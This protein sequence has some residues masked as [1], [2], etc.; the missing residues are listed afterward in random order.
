M[1]MIQIS[2]LTFAY[3]GSY[4]NVFTGLSLRLDTDWRTG[5]VA[6]NGRGKT[7]LLN[8]LR[9]KYPF[10]GTIAAS[11]A[12][13]YFPF[14]VAGGNSSTL[15]VLEEMA[16]EVESW[17]LFKELAALEVDEGAL[18]RPFSTLSNGERTKCLLAL[19]FLRENRFLLIDEPTN[20]LDLEGRGAVSR[21]LRRQK[22]FLL[23]S[24][25][26]AFLD[27]CVDHIVSLDKTGVTVQ[28]GD[29]SSW[30]ENRSRQEQWERAE[31]E[32]L[33]A[34]ISRLE[35]AARRTANWSDRIEATKI[36]Q[37]GC[38]RGYVG[39]QAARMMKRSKAIQNRRQSAIEEKR[40]LLKN[41]EYAQELKL[42]PLPHPKRRLAEI[43]D[44]APDYGT[45]PICKPFSFTVE[46]GER[47]ALVGRNGAGKSSLLK[48]IAGEDIPHAGTVA[49]A[50]GLVASIVPQDPSFLSGSPVEYAQ[51]VGADLTL[52]LTLLRK[53][54]FPRVQFA[55]DMADYSA[56]Q[57][58]KVLLAA[59]LCQEAHLY[60]WDEPLNYID[61]FSRMQLEELL[62]TSPATVL[63][64]EHDRAF[65]DA[66]C[67]KTVAWSP[68]R[69]GNLNK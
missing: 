26:R 60:I 2:D 68:R 14:P 19:L 66:V 47:V 31:N 48:S 50:S 49:L 12:F 39:H 35:T 18:Y 11:A 63:L 9:G 24:H 55:K 6:R 41:V 46:Q 40:S 58:K 53:L 67:T 65:L 59:S 23:V 43:K 21:Y 37:E 29:F 64:V 51:G 17:R 25:D 52:F 5:L 44:F 42:H 57:K 34:D 8:L 3:P 20:H 15:E 62:K 28:Q 33:A 61:V 7:T 38:D 69:K 45:G 22:G 16:P 32:K 36:G 27:G 30:W 13:D 10:R 4:D 1:S 54:D 56:G